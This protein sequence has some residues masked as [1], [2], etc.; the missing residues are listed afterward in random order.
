MSINVGT[1]NINISFCNRILKIFGIMWIIAIEEHAVYPSH[2][3]GFASFDTALKYSC[4]PS[5]A[6]NAKNISTTYVFPNANIITTN[7]N[8]NS[9]DVTLFISILSPFPLL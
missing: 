3:T 9:A 7:G 6:I 4:I 5:I 8:P 1:I 2:L